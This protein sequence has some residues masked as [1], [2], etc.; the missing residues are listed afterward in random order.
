M[1]DANF[2][3]P[4]LAALYDAI[5]SRTEDTEFYV[6]Q[7][8][9]TSKAIV[10]IG[11]GTGALA[12]PLAHRGHR[13]TGIDP[14]RPMLD[15]ARS[16]DVEG[17]VEWLEG[18]A[19]SLPTTAAFDLAVMTGHVFQVFLGDDDIAAV[20]GDARSHLR[21]GG[22]LMFETRNPAVRAWESWVPG[23]SRRAFRAEDGS[24]VIVEHHLTEVA[25]DLVSFATTHE[26][27]GTGQ[28]L[29]SES[30]LRFIGPPALLD[31]LT[32]AGFGPITFY[33]D[34]DG[35]PFTERSSEIIAIARTPGD[36]R[37]A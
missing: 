20:L 16:K 34:W 6:R 17:L 2:L 15:L 4:R 33:G 1:R 35:S 23:L 24:E 30:T 29:R 5:N 21:A 8:G 18:D 10:D 19:R 3:D 14:A 37:I 25:G 7:A 26:L 31:H 22:A 36:P 28:T 32:A 11:C 12:L 9:R 13:V 27:V